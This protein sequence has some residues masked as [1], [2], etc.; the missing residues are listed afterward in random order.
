MYSLQIDGIDT[1]FKVAR[2][3]GV[4]ALSQLFEL[5]LTVV[6]DEG[7]FAGKAVVGEKATVVFGPPDAPLRRFHGLVRRIERGEH[8]EWSAAYRVLVAP[9]AYR[10]TLRRDVRIF[11]DKTVPEIVSAVLQGAGLATPREALQAS[12]VK[13]EY[14]VQYRESDW[15]FVCRL[16]ENEG[17]A[18]YFEHG[19]SEETLV[20]VDSPSGFS[21]LEGG[22]QLPF[23]PKAGALAADEHVY[24]FH[25][26][27]ELRAG[28]ATL[29][30]YDFK[31]PALTLEGSFD[32]GVQSKLELYDYPCEAQELSDAAALAQV[33]H[34]EHDAGRRIGD[35]ESG[36]ARVSAGGIFEL[37]EHPS[38][39][40]NGRYLI[41]RTVHRGCDR[42]MFAVETSEPEYE[43]DFQS[44]PEKV[45][46]RPPRHA[47]EPRVFGVHTALVVG[48]SGDEIHVDEHGRIKVQFHWDRA[49]KKDDKSSCWVRVAQPWAGSGFGAMFLPRVGH[50]VVVSFIEGD[51]D[52]PLVTGSVYNGVNLPPYGLPD[53]KTRSTVLSRS[54]PG[55]AAG[56]E[57]RF[58]DKK[59][60]EEVFLHAQ[61]DLLVA[62]ENDAK[63]TIGG[64]S[65][66]EITKTHE[67]K[68]GDAMTV[69]VEKDLTQTVGGDQIVKINGSKLE[70]TCS[71]SKVTISKDK[72]EIE[73]TDVS[74]KA[75]GSLNVEASGDV[76]VKGATVK[77]N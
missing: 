26:D 21:D 11:Q 68:V 50:E 67:L 69:K 31:R 8:G 27:D 23:R 36:C 1:P 77:V 53:N 70:I 19:A 45:P 75:S 17:I 20:L 14:C 48:P 49:G 16:L 39:E 2:V 73:A 65:S 52:R 3:Y 4:E 6:V 55:G 63:A 34:E 29:R 43:N 56:N 5:E 47:L 22:A 38:D 62:V 18:F 24:S 30:D 57:L 74:V 28:K 51:P 10:L 35:G 72:V 15:N 33:R 58:E 41:T 64:K 46:F 42:G 25:F 66:V 9:R 54:S 37:T 32:D 12:Y 71:S 40:V 44:I 7:T 59:D 13:R 60:S 76:K 61:K